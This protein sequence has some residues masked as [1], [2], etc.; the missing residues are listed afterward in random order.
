METWLIEMNCD[1]KSY[2][3]GVMTCNEDYVKSYCAALTF[4]SELDAYGGDDDDDYEE[5]FPYVETYSYKRVNYFSTSGTK[6]YYGEPLVVNDS[7]YIEYKDKWWNVN[8]VS[9]YEK[10]PNNTCAEEVLEDMELD[11]DYNENVQYTR[12]ED[13]YLIDFIRG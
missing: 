8:I 1:G 2:I 5:P 4:Q 6:F 3:H 12:F 13:T 11:T 7:K 10:V 9:Q